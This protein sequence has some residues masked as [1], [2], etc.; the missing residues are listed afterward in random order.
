MM[1]EARRSSTR[2]RRTAALALTPLLL[3]LALLAGAKPAAAQEWPDVNVYHSPNDTGDDPRSETCPPGCLCD[4]GSGGP[5][6]INF[7]ELEPGTVVT[8]QYPEATFSGDGTVFEVYSGAGDYGSS[9][10]HWIRAETD[11]ST[12]T[13]DLNVVFSS[14]VQNLTFIAATPISSFV[15][16][17]V[18]VYQEGVVEPTTVHHYSDYYD[19]DATVDLTAFSNVTRIHIE[20]D[21]DYGE[22]AYDDFTFDTGGG[23]YDCVIKGG[24]NEKIHLWI[25]GGS[26]SGDGDI[27]KLPPDGDT[28]DYLCGA[29][30]RIEITRGT[31]KLTDFRP[32]IDTL[33][34]H[35]VC[36][37]PTDEGG[38][39]PL[40]PDTKRIRMNF[41]RGESAIIGS[42]EVAEVL[43]DSRDSTV[44][45]PTTLV[46]SGVAAA[47]ANLQ[48]RPIAAGGPE[49]I[50]EG[51]VGSQEPCNLTC[52]FAGSEGPD[53]PDGAV[54][55]L[56]YNVVISHW[57]QA[58]PACTQG[59]CDC[60]GGVGLPDFSHLTAEW[61][62]SCPQ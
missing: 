40:P 57:G 3:A 47:S 24:E 27:C 44:G 35:P 48:V 30:I 58:V 32:M 56:D 49:V 10:Q 4:G 60:N 51:P 59:D 23:E 22:A 13:W 61:G 8:N 45:A 17:D 29:D 46:V 33:V 37:G 52:D 2:G 25:D 28:G 14:P 50:A 42:Q 7:D 9:E 31:G 20:H 19:D 36:Q 12:C 55:L 41:R 26:G 38:F 16:V 62:Q 43:V 54:G 15:S 21:N 34:H 18:H 1:F 6:T 11:C 39:C 5:V 53:V